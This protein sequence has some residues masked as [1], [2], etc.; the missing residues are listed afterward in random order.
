MEHNNLEPGNIKIM[1]LIVD[2][3]YRLLRHVVLLLGV[4]I[5]LLFSNEFS[6]Q[7]GVYRYHRILIVYGSLMFMSYFNM[8]FLVPR[9]FFKGQYFIYL[10]LLLFMVV[11]CEVI[12]SHTM[13]SFFYPGA[14]SGPPQGNPLY[15]RIL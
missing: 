2:D 4:L 6:A 8:N 9:F 5:M 1:R 14:I 15:K 11:V 13:D 12:L 7:S 3:R 10:A